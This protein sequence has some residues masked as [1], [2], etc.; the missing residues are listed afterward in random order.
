MTGNEKELSEIKGYVA[1]L[2][3]MIR[4]RTAVSVELTEE[5]N[6]TADTLGDTIE[7]INTKL[8]IAN[9]FQQEE[10]YDYFINEAN[11]DSIIDAKKYFDEEY[12]EEEIRLMKI[13]LF[14]DLAN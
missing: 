7:D 6:E 4:H 10:I 1:R 8:Q 11:N 5:Q 14:S 2:Y 9:S 12:D 3:Q 13:K